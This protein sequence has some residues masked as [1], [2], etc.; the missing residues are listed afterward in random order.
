MRVSKQRL[1][2][3]AVPERVIASVPAEVMG[4]PEIERNEGT[5]A[6]T[7]VTVPEPFVVH[8]SD[9]PFDVRT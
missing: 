6:S 4:E 2:G 9:D 7:E 1:L 5:D 8:K 3:R